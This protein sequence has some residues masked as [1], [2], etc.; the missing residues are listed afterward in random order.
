MTRRVLLAIVLIFTATPAGAQWLGTISIESG[1]D[2]NM[3]RNYSNA[4]AAST[5][6]TLMYGYFPEESPW[7]YNFV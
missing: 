5:D 3:F 4:S 7:S 6:L 1:Y 2:D